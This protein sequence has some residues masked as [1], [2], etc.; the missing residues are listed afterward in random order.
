MQIIRT[1]PNIGK[2][3]FAGF[4]DY[5]LIYLLIL[6]FFFTFGETN[7][8]G[9]YIIS[10]L[11]IF[12]QFFIWFIITVGIE[13]G[14]GATLGNSIVGLKAIS[15]N[16][17]N[18]KLTFGESFLRH[19]FDPIDMFLFGLV[20]IITINNTE[21]NQRVG[22]LLAKTIVVPSKYLTELKME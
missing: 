21:R 14:L 7:S 2:R 18:R 16:G 9:E 3:I 15:I 12:I 22:D 20:G 13:I 10:G 11:S 19:L 4:I 6:T 8:D 17:T 1:Q 5:L